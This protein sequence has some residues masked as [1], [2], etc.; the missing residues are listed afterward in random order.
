MPTESADTP[1]HDASWTQGPIAWMARNPV[2][3]NLMM[4][5]L[6]FGGMI[7]LPSIKQEVFPE[8][9]LDLSIVTVPYPGASPEEVEQGIV[10]VVEEAVRG[11]DG[12]KRVT[13]T[14]YEGMGS[15]IVEPLMGTDPDRLL[16]DVKTAVDRIQ[17]F[18]EE[19]ENPRVSLFAT[20]HQVISLVL[21]GDADL[22]TLH[23]LAEDVR[24]DLLADPDITQVTLKGIPPLEISIEVSN[25]TQQA[26]G[27]TLQ[28]IA[29]QIQASSLELPA[30]ALKTRNGDL[31]VRL[32]DRRKSGEEF[33]DIVI[34]GTQS[35]AKVRLGDIATVTDGF[36]NL[37]LEYQYNGEAAVRLQAYRVGE[38]TPTEV[39]DAIKAH[40]ERLNHELPST[41]RVTTWEDDSQLLAERI[42]L[43]LNN[44]KLGLFLVVGILT[45][46][47]QIRLAFWVALGIPIS[48]LGALFLMPS[49]DISLNMISLFAFIITL[50]LVVDD[51]II[52]GENIFERAK[53]EGNRLKA[54]TEGARQMAVPVTFSIITTIVAFSPMLFVPGV[55]GK[56]FRILPLVV[57]LVLVFS[58]LESFFILPAHLAHAAPVPRWLSSFLN[59]AL[60]PLDRLQGAVSRRLEDF[61]ERRYR[62]ALET[63][64]RYRYLTVATG[65]AAFILS[66]GSIASGW[67]PF[68]FFPVLEGNVVTASARLP[69]G[70]S[71]EHSSR[72]RAEL[73]DSANRTILTFGDA[74]QMVG[75]FSLLGE[76]PPKGGPVPLPSDQGSHLVTV[77]VELLPSGDRDFLAEEFS[78][79]WAQQMQPLAALESISFSSAVG[80]GAGSVVD[81]MLSHADPA[82]LENASQDLASTLKT[83]PALT[84]I[85]DSS[86]LGKP[87]LDVSLRPEAA[88]LGLTTLDVAQ[89]VRSSLFGA[90]ALREQRDRNELQVRVRLPE[91][92]RESVWSLDQLNVRT[93][94]GNWVPVTSVADIVY[95]SSP[96]YIGREGGKRRVNVTADLAIGARSAQDVL[97]LL[98]SEYLPELTGDYP[99]LAAEF[100]GEQREQSETK[101][102]MG[103]SYIIALFVMYALLAIPFRSYIQPLIVLGAIPMGFVG[104][105]LGHLLMGYELSI[106]SMFGVVALSG[107]VINDSLVLIDSTNR[108]RR[109]GASALAAVTAGGIRRLR[110]I[111]LT[112]LTTFFGLAPMILETSVQARFL[113]P[114]AISLGFGVLFST[115]IILVMVPA[116]YM[117][118][119]DVTQLGSAKEPWPES[120]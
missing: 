99:G 6:L 68:S 61:K 23:L 11:L 4:F 55:S 108:Y 51:A 2:A 74:E 18:P 98:E 100:A 3:A 10:L 56:L 17:S 104:A 116:L 25:A 43:L 13:S 31:L 32:A 8:F 97:A 89:Q 90:E 45:L 77:Q 115:G 19:A 86:D 14:A 41:L 117:I 63:A 1:P 62:P 38:E 28:D 78:A 118:V 120:L 73:E 21:Y 87:Q 50:G 105:V 92:E 106:I 112:S 36:M 91:D 84:N 48:F 46:F 95:D 114:M 67:V 93:P 59:T 12:V 16:A 72:V 7:M 40:V 94:S 42:D 82:T 79:E 75:M 24:T 58:L 69:Y 60:A 102:A 119:D 76:G 22:R 49:T 53:E 109:A 15:I 26:L 44:A 65:L 34:R 83:F 96:P 64:I 27:L 103:R 52:V 70:V 80:P 66:I 107:V 9:S 47:L 5:I 111:L 81:V 113:I 110:P 71:L 101:Q 33:K 57:I 54:A 39:A 29:R 35:G 37:D 30:G 20:R 88:T 85:S